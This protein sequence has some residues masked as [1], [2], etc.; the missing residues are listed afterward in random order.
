MRVC[1]CV[2]PCVC[3]CA[4]ERACVRACVCVRVCVCACACARA[5][6]CV[7]V[8]AN[9]HMYVYLNKLLDFFYPSFHPT[10]HVNFLT[11]LNIVRAPNSCE[12][13]D[14]D[15]CSRVNQSNTNQVI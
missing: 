6:A 8:R 4:C 10:L 2:C 14:V 7:C 12:T 1:V 13:T 5:R 9:V 15:R 3:V 11:I